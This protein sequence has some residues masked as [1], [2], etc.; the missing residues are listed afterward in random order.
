MAKDIRIT[1]IITESTMCKYTVNSCVICTH[2]IAQLVLCDKKTERSNSTTL[3]NID[4]YVNEQRYI[5][6]Y[7]DA[8]LA[9]ETARG[10]TTEDVLAVD[11]NVM[12]DIIDST[13]IHENTWIPK[14]PSG[15]VIWN[16]N[17]FTLC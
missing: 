3:F 10:K 11:E 15:N 9:K 6:T 13:I 4:H 12:K 5:F 14:S 2:S 16:T 17:E 1:L 7:H 8:C